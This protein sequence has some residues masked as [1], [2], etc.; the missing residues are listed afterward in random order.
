M[1]K[2]YALVIS[3][4]FA[5]LATAQNPVDRDPSFN[6]MAMPEN[7]YFIENHITDIDR[8]TDGRL[9][10]IDYK[11]NKSR[12]VRL[13]NNVLDTNFSTHFTGGDIEHFVL[14]P[15]GKIIVSGGHT[16]FTQYDGVDCNKIVRLNNDGTLDNTFDVSELQAYAYGAINDLILQPDGKLL[17]LGS[18]SNNFSDYHYAMRLNA[19]GSI[20]SPLEAGR[21]F[22]RNTFAPDGKMVCVSKTGDDPFAIV[23]Y[24]TD[25]TLDS[26]FTPYPI[27]DATFV[28]QAD[29]KVVVANFE[30]IPFSN[31]VALT[32]RRLLTNGSIDPSF[33]TRT[34]AHYYATSFNGVAIRDI[35]LQTDGK[36]LI[37]G[38]FTHCDGAYHSG[39]IRL[40]TD[41]SI[42]NTF[43]TLH[44]LE[45]GFSNSGTENAHMVLQPDGKLIIASD[46]GLFNK[47]TVNNIVRLNPDGSRDQTLHNFVKGF[48]QTVTRSV[49]QADGKIIASGYFTDYNGHTANQLAR[50]NPD[51]SFDSSFNCGYG[52]RKNGNPTHWGDWLTILPLSDG[53]IV[54]AGFQ[55]LHYDTTPV[56]RIARLHPDGSL[57]TTF[58][59]GTGFDMEV[60]CGVLQADGKM[61]FGG[62]FENYNGIPKR[63]LLRLNADGS[64]DNT[65]NVTD[66]SLPFAPV[67]MLLQTDGKIVVQLSS[68]NQLFRFNTDGSRDTGFVAPSGFG[69]SHKL[70][71]LQPDGKL[72]VANTNTNV[73]VTR[74]N[75]NGSIDTGFST[76]GVFPLEV[77]D[78]AVDSDGKIVIWASEKMF[79]LN[80]DGTPDATFATPI[81]F[82]R[83]GLYTQLHIQPDGKILCLGEFRTFEGESHNRILRLMGNSVLATTD[84]TVSETA[85]LYPNPASNVLHIAKPKDS[86][87]L[88]VAIHNLLGQRVIF[89]QTDLENIDVSSMAKGHYIVRLATDRGMQN[90]RFIKN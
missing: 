90:L 18:F 27:I 84:F 2:P 45:P 58:N 31:A 48:N 41:G 66:L 68:T 29:G 76:F 86:S 49:V 62:Y 74:L 6:V 44:G 24:N 83:G 8:Q 13:D 30:P 61:I 11:V 78:A 85:G 55:M 50:L 82:D 34:F 46:F 81:G 70:K 7:H 26:G 73:G 20:D 52:P 79:R 53:K 59:T 19:D 72:I 17:C 1:R 69:M 12:F 25:G 89:K 36:I 42:D 15:D 9:L 38:N 56:P 57:D 33:Q 67:K 47:E 71:C 4:T 32:V 35:K 43:Q 60:H 5:S 21:E 75:Q 77:S 64:L 28:V 39:V 54:I 22:M 63:F 88:S 87:L 80:P 14:Q 10:V 37:T 65:F 16:Q 51:G 23:R 40:N 3:L